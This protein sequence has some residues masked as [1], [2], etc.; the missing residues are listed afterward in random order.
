VPVDR[1]NQIVALCFLMAT[2]AWGIVFYGHSFYLES[3]LATGR[4]TTSEMSGAI[5]FSFWCG[6]PAGVGVGRWLRSRTP[7]G[8]V[9]YGVL[10]IACGL[11]LLPAVERLSTL[12]LAFFLFGTGYP[13]LSTSGITGTLNQYIDKNYAGRLSW[14]LTGASV[15]GILIVPA[16][17][18]MREALGFAQ[19]LMVVAACLSMLLLPAYAWLR[20]VRLKRSSSEPTQ[21]D[22]RGLGRIV[23]TTRF[24][25][26]TVG[27]ACLLGAQVGLL[28]HQIPM[29]AAHMSLEAAA[30]G[31]SITAG[32]AIPGRFL[33]GWLAERV[34]IAL[35]SAGAGI[36]Q[37]LGMFWLATGDSVITLYCASALCG[38]VVGAIV[39]LPPLLVREQFGAAHYSELYGYSNVGLYLGAGFGPVASGILFDAF[40]NYTSALYTLAVTQVVGAALL[41][42]T[43][44]AA[45]GTHETR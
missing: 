4:F 5:A 32:S 36:V 10:A 40:G 17:V 19:A 35:L 25:L 37:A 12:Y 1:A 45:G 38:F 18:G 8:V 13:C 2:F 6:I 20:Q 16:M 39:M 7:F 30:V 23:F 24:L 21:V 43:A 33:V 29:L 15:G 22:K 3:I 44:R 11:L 27:G 9:V 26:L 14:A 41:L 34:P 42:S 28:A 31:V